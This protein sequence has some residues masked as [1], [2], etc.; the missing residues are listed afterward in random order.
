[1]TDELYGVKQAS[2]T[3]LKQIS[4]SSSLAFSNGLASLISKSSSGPVSGS[5]RVRSSKDKSDIFRT[6]NKNVKKRD[7]ADMLEDGEQKHQTQEEIG[8]VDAVA[9]QRSKRRMEEKVRLY[10]AMKRGEYIGKNESRQLVDCDRKWA[11]QESRGK[12]DSESDMTG[13]ED[14]DNDHELLEYVDEFGRTRKGT[15]SQVEREEKRTRIQELARMEDEASAAR[16]QAPTNVIRGDTIQH[17]AFNPDQTIAER[18]ADLAKKRD[19]SAT[20]PP[21][22][23]YDANTEVRTKG[24]GFY[25]FS[26]D[27]EGRQKEMDELEKQRLE[28]ERARKEREE[29]KSL[30]KIEMEKRRMQIAEQKSKIEADIFLSELDPLQ[31]P[32][33]QNPDEEDGP[34][35]G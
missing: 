7:A 13:S 23:H 22:V 14:A 16:P 18:I 25:A 17:N 9:L 26:G 28:T 4:S 31:S 12:Y 29:K 6:H 20:P 24:T 19:L 5:G 32:T 1:M 27:T 8:S 21:E 33:N 10:N 34:G 2:K 11:E 15:K 3:K 35:V 30:R